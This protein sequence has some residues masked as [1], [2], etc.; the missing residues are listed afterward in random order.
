MSAPTVTRRQALQLGAG[1]VGAALLGFGGPGAYREAFAAG[2][3]PLP[4][5]AALP[6]DRSDPGVARATLVAAAGT[7]AVAGERA[8]ILLYNGRFPGPVL[9]VSEGERTEL[10]FHNRLAEPTNLHLHGLHVSP[11]QDRPFAR[12]EPGESSTYEWTAGAGTAGTY[13]Y[14]PHLHG[15]VARQLMGGLSGPLVVTGPVDELPELTAADERLL[16]L[17]NSTR[18]DGRMLV[19]GAIAPRMNARKGTVRLRLLN[20]GTAEYVRL[21]FAD[22]QTMHLIAT[23]AGFLERPVELSELLLTP[24]ERADVLVQLKP[25]S[26]RTLRRMPYARAGGA[27]GTDP[28]ALLEIVAHPQAK[29]TPL[30]GALVAV[31]A[32]R[33]T[34]GTA[35]RRVVLAV[36]ETGEYTINGH[37]FDHHRPRVEATPRSGDTEVWEIVNEHT[38]DH[39]FHLHTWPFQVL[40]RDGRPDPYRAWRDVVNLRGRQR[41]RIAIPFTDFTG[42]TVF[43]CHNADH[44]DGGMMAVLDVTAR[45]TASD[46]R[47]LASHT[48][49]SSTHAP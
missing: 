30:P 47:P 27:T 37:V 29:P 3:E 43:H 4:R 25:G 8:R 35:V 18:A 19:N 5:L 17:R 7:T 46:S 13:W 31:P 9:R 26:S 42:Q 49:R 32:L 36:N 41:V 38:S 23:D 14:H 15:Q 34:P 6:I 11:A 45:R 48:E 21:A 12:I 28:E 40:D 24:G 44:E 10:A 22:G 20:A 1:A 39:S 2:G 33:A 16:V